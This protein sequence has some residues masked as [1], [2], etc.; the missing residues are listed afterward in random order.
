MAYF[1]SFLLYFILH[2][3]IF[4]GAKKRVLF[5][6]GHPIN[7]QDALIA[8]SDIRLGNCPCIT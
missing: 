4:A 5:L 2:V 3:N 8:E 6:D 7:L 1:F